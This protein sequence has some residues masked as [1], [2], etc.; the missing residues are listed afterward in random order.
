MAEPE[1]FIR[2]YEATIDDVKPGERSVVAKIN[3][4]EVDRYRTVIE[5][6]GAKLDGYRR[7][8]IV[9]WEHG[10]DPQ[11]GT[12]PVGRNEWIKQSQRGMVA[13]TQFKDDDYSREL[14]K[15][16]QEG[17]L[18]GWSVR[19]VNPSYSAP[20]RDEIRSRP[21]LKD[22]DLV[23]RTWELGEYSATCLPG[24]DDTLTILTSRGIWFPARTATDAKQGFAIKP[25]EKETGDALESK[26]EEDEPEHDKTKRW[27]PGCKRR[28]DIAA[29]M[30]PKGECPFCDKAREHAGAK[31][32]EPA[33]KP[34]SMPKLET[35]G[36]VWWLQ[37]PDGQRTLGEV[38]FEDFGD[39]NQALLLMTRGIKTDAQAIMVS[40]IGEIQRS[41]AEL[42]QDA[43]DL[44]KLYTTGGV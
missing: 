34:R 38:T 35:D 22:C 31:Q 15:C 29:E 14:F 28:S 1:T 27:G 7:N 6:M 43:K 41:G 32:P 4:S 23:F 39:A 21:E 33:P 16:Y 30:C 10:L 8:P 13:K 5:P 36:F 2:S 11:R 26:N 24:N 40:S 3:T 19:M 12:M 17:W 18:R 44:I 42:L 25:S 9:L 37:E 20:T